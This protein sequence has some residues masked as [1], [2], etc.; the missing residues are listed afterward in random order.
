M[1]R[2]NPIELDFSRKY[3]RDHAYQYLH[4]H[5][6]GIARRLSHWRDEQLARWALTRAGEPD[7]VLD[8]P[9]GAGRFWPLLAEHP[10]RMIFA[11]DNSAD[12]LAVAQSEQPPEVVARVETFQTS[13]FDI[14]MHDSAV[15]S[16]FCMRLLHHVADPQHRL[17]MLREFHRVTRDTL[18]LSLWVD[19]NYKAWKR[20]RLERRRPAKENQNRFVVPRGLVE[21]E[22]AEA[23]FDILGHRDFLPGYAMWRVYVLRKRS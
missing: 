15:D 10:S 2:S 9:C 5:Q 8:L 21:A 23:G 7:L 16:I 14:D 13:A 3:D 6:D 11:A 22:F 19:G 17:A 20:K 18:I 12:M 1:P 4:K